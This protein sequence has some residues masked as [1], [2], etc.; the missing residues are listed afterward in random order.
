MSVIRWVGSQANKL[1]SLV[2]ALLYMLVALNYTHL[3]EQQIGAILLFTE[4]ALGLF[5]E[6]NTVSK[7][8][9]GERIDQEVDRK[10]GTGDG[11]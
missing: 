6:S 7:V 9:V 8:R 5:V 2:R 1:A 11:R 4:I 3:T 10:M